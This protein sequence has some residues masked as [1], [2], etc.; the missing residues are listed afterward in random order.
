MILRIKN[1]INLLEKDRL[2][3]VGIFLFIIIIGTLRKYLESIFI[4]ENLEINIGSYTS[5]IFTELSAFL[6]GVLILAYFSK[7]KVKKV[8]NIGIFV[9][10]LMILPPIL[11]VFVFDTS[12]NLVYERNKLLDPETLSEILTF[13][14][15]TN[16][17]P[18]ISTIGVV[19]ILSTFLYLFVKNRTILKTV[20]GTMIFYILCLFFAG[21]A[22]TPLTTG[23][24]IF[25]ANGLRPLIICLFFA[26]AIMYRE[27]KKLAINII[28]SKENLKTIAFIILCIV[29]IVIG[30]NYGHPTVY[31]SSIVTRILAIIFISQFNI[32]L[33]DLISNRIKN[34]VKQG[35]INKKVYIQYAIIL[36]ILSLI[37][38]I[39][40]GDIIFLSIILIGLFIGLLNFFSK[41]NII[42]TG[43]LTVIAF[44]IGYI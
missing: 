12:P 29:G 1:I 7:T 26:L 31:L 4:Y 14:V 38:G 10:W 30:E 15:P 20:L 8:M 17:S 13:G 37:T 25:L 19:L 27:N 3:Y 21:Q 24:S 33:W 35:L 9:I 23:L 41:K 36:A 6:C 2:N 5:M 40:M 39:I 18:G 43:L 11:D 44:L 16:Y 32:V 28:K 22:Y 34:P 42:S